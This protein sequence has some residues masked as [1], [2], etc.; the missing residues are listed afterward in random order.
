MVKLADRMK[1]DAM[2]LMEKAEQYAGKSE[3]ESI[4]NTIEQAEENYKEGDYYTSTSRYFQA[5]I[6]MRYVIYKHTLTV[7]NIDE[8]FKKVEEEINN[9]IERLKDYETIGVNSFQLIGAAEKRVKKAERYLSDAKSSKYLDSAINNLAMAKERVESAKAWLSLLDTIKKDIKLNKEQLKRRAQF[10][11]SQAESLIVYASSI[12]GHSALID[13]AKESADLASKMLDQGFYAGAVT[14]SIDSLVK[15]SISI[16]LI[17]ASEAQIA[18]KAESAK[19]S[20]KRT[21]S[22]V[23]SITPILPAAYFEYAK[24]MNN[25]LEKLMYYKLSERIAETMLTMAEESPNKTLVKAEP[26]Y[27]QPSGQSNIAPGEQ[28]EVPGFEFIGAVA[29]VAASGYF[30]YRRS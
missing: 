22:E 25:N 30:V 14:S 5:K 28:I 27:N 29:A 2:A 6:E 24:N 16:E 13:R 17:G 4:R 26:P 18:R 15:T 8:E 9:T 3:L 19:M 23:K 20:A 21:L 11:H 12:G 10:Y 7:E 1:A